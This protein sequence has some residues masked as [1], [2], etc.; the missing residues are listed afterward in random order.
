MASNLA[1]TGNSGQKQQNWTSPFHSGYSNLS[2]YIIWAWTETFEF[3]E[4]ISPKRVFPVG[5]GKSETTLRQMRQL[6][7]TQF[8]KVF[9]QR[10]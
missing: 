4:Q 3:L 2:R 9:S 7:K 5:N 8:I 1:K 6:Y 10:N